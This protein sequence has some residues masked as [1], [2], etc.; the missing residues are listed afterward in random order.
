MTILA[1]ALGFYLFFKGNGFPY[2]V[3]SY[4]TPHFKKLNFHPLGLLFLNLNF[5]SAMKL[6]T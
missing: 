3:L 6:S 5:S 1:Q 4:R 2:L